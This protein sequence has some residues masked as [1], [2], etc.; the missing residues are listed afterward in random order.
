MRR[1]TVSVPHIVVA[2][3]WIPAQLGN[4]DKKIRGRH[5]NVKVKMC[6]KVCA[7]ATPSEGGSSSALGHLTEGT[8]V[9]GLQGP[10]Q[11]GLLSV[12]CRLPTA[13]GWQRWEHVRRVP[14]QRVLWPP[15]KSQLPKRAADP[16]RY[17]LTLFRFGPVA[18]PIRPV[19]RWIPAMAHQTRQPAVWSCLPGDTSKLPRCG[20]LDS[21]LITRA[22]RIT[23]RRTVFAPL[24]GGSP[25]LFPYCMHQPMRAS[26]L[27]GGAASSFPVAVISMTNRS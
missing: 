11:T 23:R 5:R 26:S 6:P 19:A 17:W 27:A 24:S 2:G 21:P 14:S 9:L 3:T 22:S 25:R 18:F 15:R 20:W 10:V 16:P 7:C 1:G 4:D 13:T 12:T 8:W